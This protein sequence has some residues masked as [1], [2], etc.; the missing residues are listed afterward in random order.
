MNQETLEGRLL[1]HRRILQLMLGA[2]AGTPAGTR[3]EALLRDR[4]I[5]HD[6][7][8]DPGAVETFGMGLELA[9]ADEFRRVVE[10]I[11]IDGAAS[12]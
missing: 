12:R 4:S 7:Q 9:V 1:A 10:G 11:A 2:L 8:E 5:L 3:I 6:G